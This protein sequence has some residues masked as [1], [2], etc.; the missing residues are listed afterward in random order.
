MLKL[1]GVVAQYGHITALK[2][3]DLEVA[4]GSVVSLIGA[5]GAGKSTTMKIITGLMQAAAGQIT[6]CGKQIRGLAAHQTVSRGIS[7]APEGRQ[8]LGRMTVQENLMIGACQ[9]RDSEIQADIRKIFDRFPI[10]EERREQP[11]GALSGGQQQ[12]LAIGRALM[13]RPKLLLLDEPSMG[14]A[15]LV[16]AD[17]FRIIREINQEGVTILLVEQNV[18]Q[19]LKVAHYAYVMETGKIILHGKAEE[20]AHNP[21]VVEAYLGGKQQPAQAPKDKEACAG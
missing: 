4:A 15:P 9:R 13:A 6:F 1:S 17:I 21:R 11:G 20:I 3:I 18:R 7:L 2:G 14:L 10:L 12:M 5:N 8:I 19:A 16:V